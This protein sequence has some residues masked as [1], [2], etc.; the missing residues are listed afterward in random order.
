MNEHLNDNSGVTCNVTTS[1]TT[2]VFRL[3]H[4]HHQEI[5]V[6]MVDQE[7]ELYFNWVKFCPCP[8]AQRKEVLGL[9]GWWARFR[10]GR[11]RRIYQ[12]D[13]TSLED[14]ACEAGL[15]ASIGATVSACLAC[16]SAV[17][18]I[19]AASRVSLSAVSSFKQTIQ[20]V[21]DRHQ[22]E[23]GHLWGTFIANNGGGRTLGHRIKAIHSSCIVYLSGVINEKGREDVHSSWWHHFRRSL[24]GFPW[25]S[26][27]P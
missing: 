23:F 9:G 7:H 25:A 8:V 26:S 22:V 5:Y 2:H 6:G 10:K 17:A 1:V 16:S 12:R 21:S 27:I 3:R 4:G 19:A 15:P 20:W 24:G 14:G 11:L 13:G 18:V